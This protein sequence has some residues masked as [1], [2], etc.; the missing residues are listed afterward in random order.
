MLTPRTHRQTGSGPTAVRVA[1]LV[2]VVVPW[3]VGTVWLVYA[4]WVALAE[5]FGGGGHAALA[6]LTLASIV[7]VV[8][9]EH[10]A[11]SRMADPTY[12]HPAR[13]QS[14]WRLGGWVPQSHSDARRVEIV[15]AS[16]PHGVPP[17]RRGGDRP[18]MGGVA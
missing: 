12:L 5:F 4:A 13:P 15:P 6:V 16:S 1:L 7:V 17:R 3:W 9:D 18:R 14:P 8:V 10:R 11:R 2:A